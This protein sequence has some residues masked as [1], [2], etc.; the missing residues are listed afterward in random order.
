MVSQLFVGR[1]RSINALDAAMAR[2]KDI[3]LAA[4]KNA[5]T[6]EPTPDD[7]FQVGTLGTIMQLLR[8]PDGTVKVLVE[9]K[10]RARVK[11]FPQT[12]EYFL[13][14]VEEVAEQSAKGVEVEALM[15]SVQAAFEMYV[16]LNKKVQ[17][18]VL[19]SAQTIDDAARLSDTIV[20][21]LPTIKLTDRQALLEMEDAV[22]RLE[23]L[24]ELM[25]A[26]IEILQVEKKI[27]SRVKK[28]MEKTQ[29]EYYLNEQMQAIQKELGGG[30]RDEFKNEIQE[31][32][33]QLKTKRM[34]K[35]ATAKVKKELKKLKMMHPTSAE[36]TVVRN[37]IDWILGL[38]WYD[39]SEENYD[40]KKAEEVLEEDHYGLKKIKERILEYLAVQALTKKLKGPVL[41]LVG[42]PG[43]G[44][45]SLARSIA[46]ATG[47]KFQRLSLGGVRDEAEIRGHR[48]TYIGALPGKLIQSLKKVGTNNPVFL[49]DEIDKMSTDFRGDPAA[50]LLEVLDPEQ[51]H[52]F[53]DHYL[54]M[55]YDLSD[56]MFITTA[57]TLSGIPVPLQDRM[58]I[59]QLSGY[60]EFEKM[61]IAVKYLVP[62][63]RKE[64]G[65]DEVPLT[66]SENAIRT[67]IHHYTREAGVR[68]LEREIASI[69]RKVARSVVDAGEA[70]KGTPVEVA[71]K[72]VPQYL[73]V[74]KFRLNKKE[75]RD[76][77]GLTNGL[78][79]TN[80]GGGE[81]LACEVATV[82]GKGKLV[83]TGLLEKGMEESA[84]AAMS[85]VRSRAGLLGLEPE[86]YQKLDVHVH[87]PEFIRKDGPSAG[88]TMATSLASALI[89]VPVKR[90]LAMT[91]ELTLR[92]RV[93][94]IGGLKEKL[95]AA[96]RAGITTVI[97]PRENR[98][99]L[100]EVPRR[101]LKAT[102][103]VL[104]EHADEV[105][106]EALC[107]SDPDALFG[108]ARETWEY[109][110]GE[111]VV[112]RPGA[113]RDGAAEPNTPSLVPGEGTPA[114][115]VSS[116]NA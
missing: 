9:G 74:P 3:F 1:E 4:Q 60:T 39:K 6:N 10:R 94:A 70:S 62:R 50:A 97:I 11:R 93:M 114:V 90:D 27:R 54:D 110:D 111:L 20:A 80:S 2:D 71:A 7:I 34:S 63:Q 48:R 85:Y 82:A 100:R 23:R 98:K 102:R 87:F 22:K 18:E 14:E 115:A 61:N 113:K 43:V 51:N 88:V 105:L 65:L 52:A 17:P 75:E 69:C 37:Y 55:D 91:G 21:N 112:R 46:R 58:E 13:V 73:G 33:E 26:E 35:E 28:Q 83:I 81:L 49:L 57:N 95:L 8:L 29:K 77:V 30:D 45:T 25:Q 38:P 12:E 86:F 66:I 59:I 15:R 79:V 104:V 92:G 16:K 40:L 108:P 32:E 106:R 42:P 19:M 101:V 89:K 67:V 56:V 78:S 53:N 68:S 36:A 5:K 41:C 64:C 44:K 116:G 76:E 24:H 47:R 107:L 109:I 72:N 84:Q 96:H 103:I 31:V 99:D